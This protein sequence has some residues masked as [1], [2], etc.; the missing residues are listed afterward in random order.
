MFSRSASIVSIPTT[1]IQFKQ[2]E[3]L[4]SISLGFQT[5]WAFSNDDDVDYKAQPLTFP[6]SALSIRPILVLLIVFCVLV[7][8]YPS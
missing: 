8:Q 3:Y 4:L 7:E 2:S 5:C 1:S 6:P